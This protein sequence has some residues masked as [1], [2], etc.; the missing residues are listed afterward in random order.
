VYG[1]VTYGLYGKDKP[2]L[3]VYHPKAVLGGATGKDAT[4]GE[5]AVAEVVPVADGKKVKFQFLVGGKPAAEA[6]GN[7]TLPGGKKEK[8]KTDKDGFTAAFDAAGRYAV[9]L[10]HTEAKAGEH[11]GQKYEQ[12]MHYATLV[13][14][15][16]A[17]K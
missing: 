5:K 12:V 15:S 17:T 16:P 2:G 8:V 4:A 14:D 3:L 10:K 9:Y 7:V 6:E 1:S 11:D 13:A